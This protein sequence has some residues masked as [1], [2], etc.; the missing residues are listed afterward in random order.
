MLRCNDRLSHSLAVANLPGKICTNVIESPSPHHNGAVVV[1]F[2]AFLE[3]FE[4][5]HSIIQL[6]H[7]VHIV[8]P[9]V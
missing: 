8:F 1:A 3:H 6:F 5:R 7:R 9:M 4:P 2:V